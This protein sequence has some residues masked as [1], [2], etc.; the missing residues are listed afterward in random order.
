M[1]P[2]DETADRD[3]HMTAMTMPRRESGALRAATYNVRKCVGLD[4]RRDPA[5]V[6]EVVAGLE[7]DVVAL[8]EAD[9]RLGA[10]PAAIPPGAIAPETGMVPVALAANSPSLGWHGNAILLRRDAR[11]TRTERLALPHFEPRGAVLVEAVIGDRA[12]RVVGTHLGLVRRNRVAQYAALTRALAARAPMPTILMGDF[13]DWGDPDGAAPFGPGFTVHAPGRSYHAARPVAALDRVA[14]CAGFELADAGVVEDPR[15]RRA[16][17][18][19][20]VWTDLRPLSD[21]PAAV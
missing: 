8:Q 18:H 12:L 14:H 11:V 21:R 15:A 3:P 1:Y 10:R 5:R 17:D 13:N 9:R 7:A 2:G 16:S 4:R 6:L 19:L 20:P